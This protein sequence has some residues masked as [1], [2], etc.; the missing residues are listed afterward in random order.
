MEIECVGPKIKIMLNGKK[1][2][3][4][5]QT[6]IKELRD[7]PLEGYVCLQNHGSKIEFRNIKLRDLSG[8]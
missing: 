1:I 2:I 7:K 8:K 4:I 3:D 5:D 6:K